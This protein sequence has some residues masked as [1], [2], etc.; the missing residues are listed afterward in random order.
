[1]R[2]RD[3]EIVLFASENTIKK[4][5]CMWRCTIHKSPSTLVYVWDREAGGVGFVWFDYIYCRFTMG[6]T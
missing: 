1:V 4:K 6:F 2:Q 5:R 3:A